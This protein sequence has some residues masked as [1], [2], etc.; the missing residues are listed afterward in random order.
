M[1][2]CVCVCVFNVCVCVCVCV[3]HCILHLPSQTIESVTDAGGHKA[4]DMV[5]LLIL[6]SISSR[7]KAVE[8]LFT[9]KVRGGQ[10]TEDLLS[11]VFKLSSGVS[12]QGGGGGA[13]GRGR[14]GGKGEVWGRGGGLEGQGRG[15]GMGAGQSGRCGGQGNIVSRGVGI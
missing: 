3:L 10:F 4:V 13:R 2:A 9:S 12:N 7:R 15:R 1:C 11:S 8:T 5:V 6:H 14:S